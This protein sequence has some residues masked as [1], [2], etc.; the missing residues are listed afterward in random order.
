MRIALCQHLLDLR[1]RSP[2]IKLNVGILTVGQGLVTNFTGL[3]TLRFFIGALEAGLIPG[4]VYLLAQYYP[5]YELQ[6]R[7]S[8][9]M[10]SNALSTAFGGLLGFSIAD[11]TSDNGYKPWRWLF[12][13]EGCIT[14]GVTILAFPFL[15]NWPSS[16]KWL[17][18][19]EKQAIADESKPRVC[20]KGWIRC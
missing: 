13:I 2:I 4:S 5:R 9:L 15:P 18:P 8:M 14:A 10:V 17:T 12:I 11:I 1:C 6:W 19:Q 20:V 3:V 7:V 16:T